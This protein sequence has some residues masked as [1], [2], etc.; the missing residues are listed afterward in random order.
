MFSNELLLHLF[1]SV[2]LLL[3]ITKSDI[4]IDHSLN[5][6]CE[7]I[8]FQSAVAMFTRAASAFCAV[9]MTGACLSYVPQKTL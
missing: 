6:S 4:Q 8:R 9:T 3:Y 1:V 5:P 7:A 2:N